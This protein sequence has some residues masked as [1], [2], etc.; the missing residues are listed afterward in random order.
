MWLTW[1]AF[2]HFRKTFR[3]D[4]GSKLH[5]SALERTGHRERA[6]LGFG[7]G[8]A[9]RSRS[10]DTCD[11]AATF[12]SHGKSICVPLA[13]TEDRSDFLKPSLWQGQSERIG[14]VLSLRGGPTVPP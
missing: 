3:P 6:P 14:G 9:P 12:P 10:S 8:P 11:M 2:S 13:G 4:P 1:A 5:D 7:A